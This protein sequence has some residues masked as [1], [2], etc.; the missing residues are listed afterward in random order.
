MNQILITAEEFGGIGRGCEK[1]IN[2]V[3]EKLLR[4][5]T[6]SLALDSID[7]GKAGE[8]LDRCRDVRD[9][10]DQIK[11]ADSVL[12]GIEDE[13]EV[14]VLRIAEAQEVDA[15]SGRRMSCTVRDDQRARYDPEKW[16]AILQWAI[17][18][19]HGY[20]FHRRMAD[21]KVEQLAIDGVEFPDGLTLEPYKKISFRRK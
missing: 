4:Y 3:F 5:K 18:N 15:L 2:A 13:I 8:L 20:I 11:Q 19:G 12:G 16:D 14:H 9:A 7:T 21:A 17:Q 1:V 10:R 6:D